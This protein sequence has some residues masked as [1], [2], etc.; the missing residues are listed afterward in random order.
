LNIAAKI[1]ESDN[2][3]WLSPSDEFMVYMEFND[4]K[5]EEMTYTTYEDPFNIYPDSVRQRYPK[6]GIACI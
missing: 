5:V 2:A 3:I 1:F 6:V 4:K